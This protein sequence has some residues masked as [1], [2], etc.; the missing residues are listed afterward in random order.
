[1]IDPSKKLYVRRKFR[2]R[3]RQVEDLSVTAEEKFEKHFLKRV[4]GL[5]EVRRF[6][7]GW[8]TFLILLSVGV[9]MQIRALGGYYQKLQ[10][11][12][13][14]I[15]TEGMIG[16]FTNASPLYATGL[17]DNTVSRLV[18]SGLLKYDSQNKIVGDL[19]E[20]WQIDKDGK[21]YK[22][23][24]KP[25]LKWHDGQPLTA[26]DVVFT[27]KTIQNPDAKSPLFSAWKGVDITANDDRTVTFKIQSALA[28]FIYSL[29]TGIVP[30]HILK[31]I[32]PEQLR[33]SAFNTSNPIGA[34]P[35][36]WESI[37][38]LPNGEKQNLQNIGLK[39]NKSYHLG[40]TKLDKFVIKTFDSTNQMIKSLK[41]HELN[42]LVGL[43]T[44]PDQLSSDKNIIEYSTPL[45]A[46]TGVFF[47]TDTGILSDVK[48]RQ[49]LVQATNVPQIV[50]GLG[51]PVIVADSPLLDGQIGYSDQFK[52][53][54]PNI[55]KANKLLDEAGW[56]KNP[57]EKIRTKDQKKLQVKLYAQNNTDYNYLTQ[58]IQKAWREIGV[59][60][61]VTLPSENEMQQIIDSRDYDAILHGISIGADPD[62]FAY[63]HSSQA[64]PRA[65]NRL[66]FS[67]YKSTVADKSLEAGR[68]RVDAVLRA[69][70]YVPFLQAWSSDAPALMLY[71]PRFLYLTNGQLFG[72]DSK[73]MN[74]SADRFN[75]V[76][77]WEIIQNKVLITE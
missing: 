50:A 42:S 13:G 56:I 51:Y 30:K 76:H 7:L 40:S 20:S 45:T 75:N 53:L 38:I 77:N 2:R 22:I 44:I 39:A 52:Q 18:F 43:D 14:G 49:A 23:I 12:V 17:T 15:Y 33:S 58:N 73:N 69:A 8:I 65:P 11:V 67:N 54:K 34:G 60:A 19:A 5:F 24:L 6:V 36:M 68:S 41:K 72:F 16:S 64:D 31:D 63:W 10:P 3:R 1:M 35:F 59:D 71:Q 25:D 37:E 46:I 4:A 21:Q 66:N 61:V 74:I 26:S 47:K 27:F 28:P 9:A 48:I 70:K 29:T 55:E 57:N 62:V 32:K